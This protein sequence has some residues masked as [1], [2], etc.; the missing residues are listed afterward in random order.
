MY[1]PFQQLYFLSHANEDQANLGNVFL[2]QS[3]LLLNEKFKND[4]NGENML[5]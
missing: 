4:V 3:S 2:T 5:K 1:H